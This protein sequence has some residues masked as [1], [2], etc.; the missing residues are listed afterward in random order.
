[1]RLTLVVLTWLYQRQLNKVNTNEVMSGSENQ[2]GRA[3][4]NIEF[5]EPDITS[6]RKE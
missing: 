4:S 1:M 2:F 3:I 5:I 6:D